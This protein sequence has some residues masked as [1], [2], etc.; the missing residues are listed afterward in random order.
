MRVTTEELT[1]EHSFRGLGFLKI[2]GMLTAVCGSKRL[3]FGRKANV[4]WLDEQLKRV[5]AEK[6]FIAVYSGVM[7]TGST[8]GFIRDANTGAI[9]L[10]ED[11]LDGIPRG[12]CEPVG[13]YLVPM[14]PLYLYTN[15]YAGVDNEKQVF[16]KT[17]YAGERFYITLRE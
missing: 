3:N 5:P 7:S 13:L 6:E 16:Q 1:G 4:S 17:T 9:L 14:A 11:T 8:Q 12:L 2:D 15:G 10:T